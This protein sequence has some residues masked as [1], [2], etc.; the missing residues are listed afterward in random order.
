MLV[1]HCGDPV[2]VV[3]E[4]DVRPWGEERECG[5]DGGPGQVHGLDKEVSGFLA[6]SVACGL[7]IVGETFEGWKVD[8]D[9]GDEV[10]V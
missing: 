9:E 3:E 4:D 5:V 1:G 8:G 7:D 6:M 2:G 10:R